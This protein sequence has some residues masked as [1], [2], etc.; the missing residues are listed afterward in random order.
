[1][2]EGTNESFAVSIGFKN[3][4][5]ELTEKEQ[6]HTKIDFSSSGLSLTFQC[7]P[8]ELAQHSFEPCW[9][10][11]GYLTFFPYTALDSHG[12][13]PR[14]FDPTF[15]HDSGSIGQQLHAFSGRFV[16]RRQYSSFE[17]NQNH[18]HQCNRVCRHFDRRRTRG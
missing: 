11:L 17:R 7:K 6:L 10:Y 13:K 4:V 15:N 12:I 8:F 9:G 2:I 14:S 5:F 18:P 16:G 1:M 3:R